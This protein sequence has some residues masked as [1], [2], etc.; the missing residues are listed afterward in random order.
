MG[1]ALGAAG[2]SITLAA[3][4]EGLAFGLGALT[5]MPAV[6]NF[7]LCAAMAVL[8][9]FV[10]QVICVSSGILY[11]ACRCCYVA[12]TVHGSSVMQQCD[13]LGWCIR[14][15]CRHLSE[16]SSVYLVLYLLSI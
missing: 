5:P 11:A 7:S 4:C 8:L 1:V 6:R 16:G 2:P 13:R 15:V 12:V 14:H 3:S 9:D 10:L